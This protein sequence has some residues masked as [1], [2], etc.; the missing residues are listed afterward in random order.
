MK[1]V[2]QSLPTKIIPLGE[3]YPRHDVKR[4]TQQ[5]HIE[6]N[7][8]GLDN[9]LIEKRDGEIDMDSTVR[10]RERLGEIL[11]YYKRTAAQTV[12]RVLAQ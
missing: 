6:R 12:A 5:D 2:F 3:R 9:R 10:R 11:N 1:P 7:H 4:Y 8:Q